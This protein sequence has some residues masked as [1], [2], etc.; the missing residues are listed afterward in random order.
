MTGAACL[1]FAENTEASFCVLL[2]E[3]FIVQFVKTCCAKN[4]QIV[5]EP[6]IDRVVAKIIS[7]WALEV[8]PLA[9]L[10][11]LLISPC[12]PPSTHSC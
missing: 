2:K 4:K 11:S 5:L 7:Q 8:G 1:A 3:P 9:P 6:S 12:C 10:P